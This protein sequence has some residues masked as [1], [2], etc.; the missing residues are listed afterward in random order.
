M[1]A[2]DTLLAWSKIAGRIRQSIRGLTAPELDLKGGFEEWSIREHVHHL[3]EANL[4][5]T[6]MIIA[7]L[8]T[9]GGNFD[10]TWVNPT[11]AWM[12]RL[13][14]STADV[15]PALAALAALNR[16]ISALLAAKP[17]ALNR[18]VKLNDTPGGKRYVVTIEQILLQEVDHT[19]DHLGEIRAIRKAHSS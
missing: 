12:G 7:A 13:G 14:Y 18:T 16:H 4:V 3:V 9:D 11:K 5:A 15:K 2:T 19:G 17:D 1:E 8:A 10:W 6:S